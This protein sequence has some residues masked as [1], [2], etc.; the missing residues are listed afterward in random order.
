MYLIWEVKKY[1]VRQHW[2]RRRRRR[3]FRLSDSQIPLSSF[4]FK[5]FWIH[6]SRTPKIWVW[7]MSS[8]WI[9]FYVLSHSALTTSSRSG[10]VSYLSETIGF[11]TI[12][13]HLLRSGVVGHLIKRVFHTLFIVLPQRTVRPLHPISFWDNWSKLFAWHWNCVCLLL[14]YVYKYIWLPNRGQDLFINICGIVG[15]YHVLL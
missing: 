1:E 3:L 2:V 10:L 4:W 5:W 12:A 15:G 6:T 7:F 9:P 8:V 14:A 13:G 11:L